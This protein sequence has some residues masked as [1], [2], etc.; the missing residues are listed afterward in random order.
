MGDSYL[1]GITQRQK[2]LQQILHRNVVQVAKMMA[3][4]QYFISHRQTH[5]FKNQ[6]DFCYR[7][8]ERAVVKVFWG[9]AFPLSDIPGQLQTAQEMKDSDDTSNPV[10]I[11]RA[12]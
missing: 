10:R 3:Q 4:Q 9:F 6:K 1:Y 8:P 2:T 7:W 12:F 11:R 5:D